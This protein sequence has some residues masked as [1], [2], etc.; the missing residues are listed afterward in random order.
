[1]SARRIMSVGEALIDV[2]T[3]PGGEPSEHVGGSLLNVANGV[4]RLGHRSSICSWWGRDAH[5]ELVAASIASTGAEV[6][7]GTDSATSTSVAQ[8]TLDAE[9]RAT[10][11]FDLTWDLPEVTDLAGISH[12]HTGSI[13]ATLAPGGAK[14]VDLVKTLRETATI[15]Y[16]PNVR[17]AIMGTSA[18]VLGRVEALVALSDVV[19]AS[20][21]DLE[22][23]YPGGAGR[24]DLA[25]LGRPRSGAGGVYEGG[26][27]V[28]TPCCVR[29]ATTWS[30]PRT[31]S[32]SRTR[33]APGTRSWRA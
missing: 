3:R 20:D 11:T 28:P 12:V 32:R 22:W 8:A 2:V 14:V 5:G 30:Y 29:R 7:P 10:Y 33:S 17:P 24:D 9:G 13:G 21:E 16:D 6:E 19:K 4:A 25:P 26:R 27:W 1:M 31:R 18:D 15:S 23:L